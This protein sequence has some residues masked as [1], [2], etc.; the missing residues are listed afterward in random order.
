MPHKSS[1]SIEV[2]HM[3]EKLKLIHEEALIAFRE[4]QE[5][6]HEE[7]EQNME[8][9]RFVTIAGAQ[10][11]GRLG[12]QFENKPRFEVNK[13]QL[14]L[15]RIKNEYK[16][17]RITASF[18]PSDGSENDTLADTMGDLY[19]ATERRSVAKEAYDNAF[20][21]GV[22]G[23][24]GAWR[25]STEFEDEFDPDND[26]QNI[27]ITPHFDA[28]ITI[29][30]DLG[31]K[32][33]DKLDAV[34][35][36]ALIAMTRKAYI[37]IYD[38]D[39]VSWPQELGDT[40][41]F[42]REHPDIVYV[43]EY[44]QVDE[45]GVIRE[46]FKSLEDKEETFDDISDEKRAELEVTGHKM[47]S[48]RTVKQR[49]VHKY[50]MSGSK[51]LSDESVIA[52]KFIPIVPFFGERS[53][54]KNVERASGHVRIAKDMQRLKN[55]QISWLAEIAS[56]TGEPKPIFTPEQIAGHENEW[57][58]E[59][60][61]NPAYLLVNP[62]LDKD[63][64]EA[65][66]GPLG[67]TQPAVVPPATAALL[68]ITDQDIKEVLGDQAQGEKIVSNI[69]GDAIEKIQNRIDMQTFGF[70]ANFARAVETSGIIYQ[71]MA[72]DIYTEDGNQGRKMKGIT[73]QNKTRQIELFRLITDPNTKEVKME[74]DFS[75][76]KMDIVV[77]VG[78]SSSTK[79]QAMVNSLTNVLKFAVEPETQSIITSMI[80]MNMEGEGVTE[81]REFFR[82]KLVQG[83]VLKPTEDEAKA[84]A[85]AAEAQ[86]NQPP[87][88]EEEFLQSEASKNESEVVK[89][90]ATIGKTIAET[91]KIEAETA[92]EIEGIERDARTEL[93]NEV[94]KLNQPDQPGLS[95][96]PAQPPT[97]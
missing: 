61:D 35:G 60:I 1:K 94:D 66:A 30:F 5:V 83:G 10:W 46:T 59:N 34:K 9:R 52:G 41:F 39:P 11:D 86:Q 7:R 74:N 76:A 91:G 37:D 71:S 88:A 21:E 77:E 16:N 12:D 67:Y 43:A 54:I 33:Q 93:F 40:F 63:G 24:I 58:D 80:M 50:I 2:V 89:N 42:D 28:D 45:G 68:Q 65:P 44:Y 81:V 79:R 13:I 85:A 96:Q 4:V 18:V 69:S 27:I 64:N 62:I 55:M 75:R 38:D 3:S 8:D 48:K 51:I 23:G 97:Q 90:M 20:D 22:S 14:S 25:L 15:K 49:E 32:R 72:K 95:G 73:S 19:R 84:L 31:A 29:F 82:N 36:W 57:A 87:T 56:R 47:I 70:M 92:A 17:N 53:Y 78:P 6:Q 26:L